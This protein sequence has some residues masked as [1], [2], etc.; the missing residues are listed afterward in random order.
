VKTKRVQYVPELLPPNNESRGGFTMVH[1]FVASACKFC[2][3]IALLLFSG[4]EGMKNAYDA[5][6][7]SNF[8]S[9]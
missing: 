6:P 7:N 3:F 4:N 8:Y 2:M 5:K 9:I 1:E